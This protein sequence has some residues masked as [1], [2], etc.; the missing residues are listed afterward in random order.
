M[1]CSSKTR[2]KSGSVR[3]GSIY[4]TP[5][6]GIKPLEQAAVGPTLTGK[7]EAAEIIK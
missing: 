5:K 4:E 7:Q 1:E 6:G 3:R 2:E